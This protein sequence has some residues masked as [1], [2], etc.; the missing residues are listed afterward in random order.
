MGDKKVILREVADIRIGYQARGRID[1]DLYGNFTIVRSQDFDDNGKLNLKEAM[2]FY[3]SANIDPL[4]YLISAGDILVQA[5][6]QSHLAYLIDQ[7]LMNTVA[8][9]SFY[10]IQIVDRDKV[11][12]V[13]LAWWINQPKVQAY[14]EKVIGPST[15]P[16]IT[17]AALAET[18]IPILPLDIQSKISELILLWQREQSL[19]QYFEQKK[20]TYIHAVARKAVADS[21]EDK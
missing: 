20:E 10:I 9:N 6:G 17:K 2:S 3:P 1:E 14:F 11:I 5:R 7:P 12:P 19:L 13:Y 21:M 16:F 15:I 8:A 4:K 18:S